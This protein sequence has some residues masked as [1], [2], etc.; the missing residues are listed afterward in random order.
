MTKVG[1]TDILSELLDKLPLGILITRND[2]SIVLTNR[3]LSEA[4]TE[5][6]FKLQ[7][8]ALINKNLVP[9]VNTPFH[10]NGR[11]GI[12]KKEVVKIFEEEYQYY[13]FIF[14]KNN[15]FDSSEEILLKDLSEIADDSMV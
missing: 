5:E 6:Q 10:L 9:E 7:I 4:F 15:D 11:K 3:F 13:F 12:V 2:K 8:L 1:L 14:S